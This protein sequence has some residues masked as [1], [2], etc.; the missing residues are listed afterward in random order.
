[1]HINAAMQSLIR[2]GGVFVRI[3]LLAASLCLLVVGFA[4]AAD[5]QAMARQTTRIPPQSLDSA[6]RTLA[7]ERGFH[8]VYLPDVVGRRETQG[9]NGDLTQDQ[10]L[11]QLLSGTGLTFRY[12]D[13]ETVTVIPSGSGTAS[14][15]ASSEGEKAPRSFSS[16]FRLAQVDQGAPAG[17]GAVNPPGQQS[18]EQG[19]ESRLQEIVV[20][21]QK[22]RQRAFDVPI[23]LQVVT[24]EE[25][26]QNGITDLSNLQYDVPGLYMN[27]TGTTRA[28]Y[29][30]G[31]GNSFGTGPMVGQYIDD[32]D[33]TGGGFT[34][35]SG[36]IGGD[37]GL[38][39]PARV[40]VLKGPQGTLYGDG[41]I[42]GVIR[43]ITNEPVLDRLQMSADV[44]A[45]FTQ[46]GAPSQHIEAMLNTPLVSGTLGLRFAG[47]FENDGGWV[48]EPAAN[49][50]NINSEN[51]ADVRIEGLWQPTAD[52]KVSAMQIVHRHGFGLGNG[53][54]TNGNITPL[55]DTTLTPNASDNSNISNVSVSYDFPGARLLSS[56]TYS[57]EEEDFHN[58]LYATSSPAFWELQPF[59]NANAETFSEEVRLANTTEGAWQWNVGGFYKQFHDFNG[60]SAYDGSPGQ[61][62]SEAFYLPEDE[63]YVGDSS[64]SWAGFADTSYRFLD[65]LTVGAGVRYFNDRLTQEVVG[66]SMGTETFKSTDPRFYVQ[67]SITP[68]INTY[69][70]ASKGFRSGG[71]N[72][73]VGEPAYNPET[74]WSYDVGS[75]LRFPDAGVRADVDLFYMNY[76]N[77]VTFAQTSPTLT[78][79]EN[80]GDARIRG[81][82]AELSW[83]PDEE[84][85]VSLNTEV[86][87]SKF[88]TATAVSGY[89][90]GDR[91]PYAP[92]YSFKSAIARNFQW[93]GKPSYAQLSYYEISSVQFRQEGSPL[94]ESDPLH[95]LS[96]RIGVNW[97]DKVALGIFVRNLLN[98][99]GNESPLGFEDESTRPRPRTIGLDFDLR[100]D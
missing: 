13:K 78:L 38:Y 4:G 53:E 66:T 30:R 65:R 74:L 21:A 88:L 52:L 12:L 9:A 40:E 54:D 94:A 29:L 87:N 27:N 46:D 81:V 1:L 62:L 75:K 68:N 39:D 96:A 42:G 22:Y 71:F 44:A 89:A 16:R 11:T 24:G 63:D 35:G 67:Y 3:T 28:V 10:A 99:R 43:Y 32:A 92:A 82:D 97:T 15:P 56:S 59:F 73:G 76:T 51:L 17:S 5:A 34:G 100:G 90:A 70:S 41:S 57:T 84:W 69:A 37:N 8:I 20:T 77:Y 83:R 98:D 50:K 79:L 86:A 48:D 80:V 6:L 26:L 64:H 61:T 55:F 58:A 36:Y 23:S 31:V 72:F 85:L 49:L 91:L 95:F 14:T 18:A 47:M 7:T 60:G 33:I 19:G 2:G 45:L 93:D 25:L